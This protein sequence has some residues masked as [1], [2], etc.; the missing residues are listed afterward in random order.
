MPNHVHLLFS[1]IAGHSITSLVRSW[2]GVSA[3]TANRL[4]L[5]TGEFWMRDYFDRL[6]RD[7]N[8]FWRCARYIR[9][10]PEK[11][12]LSPHDF[13]LFEDPFV[14]EQLDSETGLQRIGGTPAAATA[15]E[16]ERRQECRQSL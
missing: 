6:I 8:H 3:R 9:R 13:T 12:R 7:A 14:R 10:N 15:S 11:A 5:R 1:P 4:Q 2:K 16:T